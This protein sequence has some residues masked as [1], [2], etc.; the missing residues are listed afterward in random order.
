MQQHAHSHLEPPTP[1]AA[2]REMRR[3]RKP[4]AL[5]GIEEPRQHELMRMVALRERLGKREHQ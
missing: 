4:V 3:R 5:S 1:A 2:H